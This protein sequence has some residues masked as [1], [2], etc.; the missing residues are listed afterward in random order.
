MQQGIFL[1]SPEKD[2]SLIILICD[3]TLSAYE[4]LLSTVKDFTIIEP[5]SEITVNG[6]HGYHAAYRTR[7]EQYYEAQ[8]D[9]PGGIVS[10]IIKSDMKNILGIKD[11]I[12]LHKIVYT[13]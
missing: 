10:I 7:T 11:R 1:L 5:V 9:V 13:A 8:L 12:D 4:E 6:L 2:Y 3:D